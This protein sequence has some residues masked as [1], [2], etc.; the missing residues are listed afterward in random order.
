[1]SPPPNPYPL[2]S[3]TYPNEQV[4]ADEVQ[5]VIVYKLKQNVQLCLVSVNKR[6]AECVNHN[7]KSCCLHCRPWC[8]HSQYF[9]WHFVSFTLLMH[10]FLLTNT[11]C[12]SS[13][14]CDFSITLYIVF[15]HALNLVTGYGLDDHGSIPSVHSISVARQLPAYCLRWIK[16]PGREV[17]HLPAS[18]ADV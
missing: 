6:I 16:R 2:R 7:I 18:S 8:G 3:F 10:L 4:R 5:R 13:W 11:T 1:M 15:V 12:F 17:D 9:I 14:L